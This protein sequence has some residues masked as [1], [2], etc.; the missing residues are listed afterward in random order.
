[1]PLIHRGCG[2]VM[3]KDASICYTSDPPQWRWDCPKC[4]WHL[5]SSDEQ[6]GRHE[7]IAG[8]ESAKQ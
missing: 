8:T 3:R 2:G 6:I 7:E 1:M 4:E 5:V